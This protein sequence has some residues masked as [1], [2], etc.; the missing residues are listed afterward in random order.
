MAQPGASAAEAQAAG[1]GGSRG[2]RRSRFLLFASLSLL[3]VLALVTMD[4]IVL[5][6]RN[7]LKAL[8]PHYYMAL[9]DSI[10]FGYQPNLDFSAGFT[11][12]LFNTLRQ[13]DVTTLV[14]YACAGETTTTM[15]HGGCVAHYAH[16]GSYIGAQLTAAVDFLSKDKNQGRVSPLTLEI[17]AN[18]VLPDWD[19]AACSASPNAATDLATMDTN[20][21]HVILPELTKALRTST[22]APSGDL[23]LLNYY[24]PFARACLNSAPFIHTL[25]NHLAA[26]AAQFK[27]PVVDVYSAF[28]GDA[29]MADKICALTWYCSEFHDIHP[30]NDGYKAIAQA[31]EAALGLSGMGSLRQ[32]TGAPAARIGLPASALAPRDV[33][34]WRRSPLA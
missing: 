1:A 20:L 9:G 27:V 25:N 19:A 31:V 13:I 32:G 17:G 16:K 11:D 29:G 3:L 33:A 28:G 23:L 34:A 14:N 26:D 30:T 4:V 24:N 22:G 2:P 8:S 12:D 7:P 15:I 18:D 10:S 21:T 5:G 6:V